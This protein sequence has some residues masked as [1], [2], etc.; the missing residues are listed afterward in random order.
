M[1]LLW[2]SFANL[3]TKGTVAWS[4]I[5]VRESIV[6]THDSILGFFKNVH[7]KK[8]YDAEMT[9][10]YRGSYED[11]NNLIDWYFEVDTIG[12]KTTRVVYNM[13][14]ALGWIGGLLQIIMIAQSILL[15]PFI[16]DALVY[17]I[18]KYTTSGR[19]VDIESLNF[20]LKK[21]LRNIMCFK[22]CK[23]LDFIFNE[24]FMERQ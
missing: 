4:Y 12:H 9:P 16:K 19:D 7:T 18:A 5:R 17:Q 23:K 6:E 10:F 13:E 8:Y 2:D 1:F 15:G 22:C 24:K 11:S 3:A 14:D 20:Y 21:T